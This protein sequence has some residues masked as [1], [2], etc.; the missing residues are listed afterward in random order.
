MSKLKLPGSFSIYPKGPKP[1]SAAPHGQRT[2]DAA[3]RAVRGAQRVVESMVSPSPRP[4][5]EW[6]ISETSHAPSYR[7]KHD[8]NM[9]GSST[10]TPS[11]R[12]AQNRSLG[13][14]GASRTQVDM[15]PYGNYYFALEI[16]GM[17]VAHFQECSGLKNAAQIFE[18][19]EGGLNGTVH[20]RPGQSKWENLIFKYATSVSTFLVEWRDM[21]LR[22]LYARM[23]VD[24]KREWWGTSSG[25][26]AIINNN[27]VVA[28]RF[29]FRNAWPVSWEGPALNATASGLA[30][31]SIEIAHD[32]IWV[33][34]AA[35]SATA[36]T[37]SARR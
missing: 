7:A 11:A 20:K 26:V 19:Q 27:G 1:S 18:I 6:R 22:D 9:I 5:Q 13:A 31:E 10:H 36:D 29:H 16:N 35:W 34:D 21:Y 15:D 17:E 25:S 4:M 37:P 23:E 8:G 24:D 2:I 12:S 33:D 14:D 3:A 32:G 30:I 28:R